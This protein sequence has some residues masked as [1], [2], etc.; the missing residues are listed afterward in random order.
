MIDMVAGELLGL[1][2]DDEL[3]L[4]DSAEEGIG[5]GKHRG[6][7]FDGGDG[8][9]RGFGGWGGAARVDIRICVEVVDEVVEVG[10]GEEVVA[11]GAYGGG[12]GEGVGGVGEVGRGGVGVGIVEGEVWVRGGRGIV[13]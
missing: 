8:F 4:A 7:D 11:G 3:V 9:H 12:G 1:N 13:E 2:I 5:G 6:G 10:A